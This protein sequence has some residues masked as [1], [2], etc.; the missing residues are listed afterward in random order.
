[1][2][3]FHKAEKILDLKQGRVH[4]H[5]S[6]WERWFESSFAPVEVSNVA[7]INLTASGKCPQMALQRMVWFSIPL[8]F[9]FPAPLFSLTP[10]PW[11]PIP[12]VPGSPVSRFLKTPAIEVWLKVLALLPGRMIWSSGTG[13]LCSDSFTASESPSPNP[14]FIRVP[15]GSEISEPGR[16]C[17]EFPRW[18]IERPAD[19]SPFPAELS[20]PVPVPGCPCARGGCVP[21]VFP[22]APRPSPPALL[23]TRCF[24]A[25]LTTPG[26]WWPRS[27]GVGC[28]LAREA[29]CRGASGDTGAQRG[30]RAQPT[31]VTHPQ[32]NLRGRESDASRWTFSL[33][34]L[35]WSLFR[36]L[37]LV[38][39]TIL[40]GF[41]SVQESLALVPKDHE[42]IF[43]TVT[44][45]IWIIFSR[46]GQ[47]C[48]GPNTV[49]RA[50][51]SPWNSRFLLYAGAIHI[52]T[53]LLARKGFHQPFL[54]EFSR[55][56]IAVERRYAP[57]N[58]SDTRPC[59][60][61]LPL[62]EPLNK[63][64]KCCRPLTNFRIC[65]CACCTLEERDNFPLEDSKSFISSESASNGEDTHIFLSSKREA[66]GFRSSVNCSQ[67]KFLIVWEHLTLT[68]SLIKNYSL[69]AHVLVCLSICLS[70]SPPVCLSCCP[71]IC[72]EGSL[73]LS[74]SPFRG[75]PRV[76]SR[77]QGSPR[78]NLAPKGAKFG[79]GGLVPT[80]HPEHCR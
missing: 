57:Q 61:S 58:P 66:S 13:F 30:V 71:S 69:R 5:V 50:A 45:M 76:C 14:K 77:P 7:C 67:T 3:F 41:K 54:S 9:W 16:L 31:S 63:F 10:W 75:G 44:G 28:P 18:Q 8:V 12:L 73:A 29:V 26:P 56:C 53:L 6:L 21:R 37:H 15:R 35:S 43:L 33:Q 72:Q 59:L 64:F 40:L 60:F 20:V 23:R 4:R 80:L 70:Y 79:G 46:V 78:N 47:T 42:Q 38:W 51:W 24:P 49:C 55:V 48:S 34:S 19:Q 39:G 2:F 17:A 65:S 32:T 1:M 11:S 52:Q 22:G 62:P 74:L 25:P 27:P 36:I 68:K